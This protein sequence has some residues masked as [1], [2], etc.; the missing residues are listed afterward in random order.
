MSRQKVS[1]ILDGAGGAVRRKKIAGRWHY[2]LMR[3]GE[4]AIGDGGPGALMVDPSNGL[5]AIRRLEEIFGGLTGPVRVCDP[6]VDNKT[7][8]FLAT[9]RSA[10]EIRLLTHN[11]MGERSFRRDLSAAQR[12]LGI[13]FEV[14][15]TSA[16]EN[17]DRYVLADNESYLIGSSLNGFAKKRSFVTPLTGLKGPVLD[18]FDRDW[19]RAKKLA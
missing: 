3:T 17:H 14:R 15:V 9:M 13:P 12:Q 10:S 5:N 8:D 18:A 7:V 11:V 6:Y 1:S 16:A 4:D 2:E 19:N